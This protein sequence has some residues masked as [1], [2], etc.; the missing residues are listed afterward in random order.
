M[1]AGPK[2]YPGSSGAGYAA[3]RDTH[4]RTLPPRL[5]MGAV[6][7]DRDHHRI[8]RDDALGCFKNLVQGYWV[9]QQVVAVVVN[10]D[11]VQHLIEGQ[12]QRL[13]VG[14]PELVFHGVDFQGVARIRFGRDRMPD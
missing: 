8:Q 3:A 12:P 7:L 13:G 2:E 9:E 5:G 4:A 10:A 6:K 1:G 11:V 14:T